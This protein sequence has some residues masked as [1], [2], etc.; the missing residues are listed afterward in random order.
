MEGVFLF[1][2]SFLTLFGSGYIHSVYFGVPFLALYTIAIYLIQK[3]RKIQ[4]LW[5]L[6]LSLKGSNH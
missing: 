3:K 5:I 2:L 6:L 1:S 4:N